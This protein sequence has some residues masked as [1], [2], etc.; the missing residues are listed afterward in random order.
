MQKRKKITSSCRNTNKERNYENVKRG[1]EAS[2][3]IV[4]T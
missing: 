2:N 4:D 3:V 1:R